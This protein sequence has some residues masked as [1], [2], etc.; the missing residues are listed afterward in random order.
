MIAPV[1]SI[2]ALR[3]L[4]PGKYSWVQSSPMDWQ[5]EDTPSGLLRVELDIRKAETR[6]SFNF[7]LAYLDG[8]TNLRRYYC[9]LNSESEIRWRKFAVATKPNMFNFLLADIWSTDT[10]CQYCKDQFG[11]VMVDLDINSASYVGG[12]KTHVATLPEGYRPKWPKV[13]TGSIRKLDQYDTIKAAQFIVDTQG[14][15]FLCSATF[16]GHVY[17]RVIGEFQAT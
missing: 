17:A 14:N 16:D 9:E 8:G 10:V 11:V 1:G 4:T 3:E 15:I 12:T 5:P 6:Q 13:L 2:E 7:Y